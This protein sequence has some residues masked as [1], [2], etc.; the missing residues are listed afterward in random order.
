[1]TTQ[2]RL[3]WGETLLSLAPADQKQMAK[4]LP[5]LR[6][7]RNYGLLV[8]LGVLLLM[9]EAYSQVRAEVP[10]SNLTFHLSAICVFVC[11][12]VFGV[13]LTAY[14]YDKVSDR[15]A[16]VWRLESMPKTAIKVHAIVKNDPVAAAYVKLVFHQGNYLS[17]GDGHRIIEWD[18]NGRA[19]YD[20][21]QA[22]NRACQELETASGPQTIMS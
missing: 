17:A 1:M 9:A 10:D 6:H 4:E 11:T 3:A 18:T 2:I 14:Y 20:L 13:C 22:A 21:R 15:E 7:V 5:T 8:T 19:A 12:L 16:F